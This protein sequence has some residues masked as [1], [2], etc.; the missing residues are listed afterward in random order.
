MEGVGVSGVGLG[1][2]LV[3]VSGVHPGWPVGVLLISGH[4]HRSW[5]EGQIV[6]ANGLGDLLNEGV[7]SVGSG[8]APWNVEVVIELDSLEARVTLIV[9]VDFLDNLG[10]P[11]SEVSLVGVEPGITSTVAAGSSLTLGEFTEETRIWPGG[12]GP[13]SVLEPRDNLEATNSLSTLDNISNVVALAGI[14]NIPLPGGG[15]RVHESIGVSI[16]VDP[17]NS[18]TLQLG[19]LGNTGVV[20]SGLGFVWGHPSANDGCLAGEHQAGERE[21]QNFRN[22]CR[23]FCICLI[24]KDKNIRFI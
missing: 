17:T 11:G 20:V 14:W 4:R 22:S 3:G 16:D 1:D 6:G 13:Q 9:V 2:D 24:I 10:V 12:G 7:D 19:E 23:H 15:D 5:G 18:E 8:E 21:K